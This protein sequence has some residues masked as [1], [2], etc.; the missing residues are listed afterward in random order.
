MIFFLRF[1]VKYRRLVIFLVDLS[2]YFIFLSKISIS[3]VVFMLKIFQL[4][5]SKEY[6]FENFSIKEK[7]LTQDV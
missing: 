1:R 4:P 6:L 3:M 7:L 2:L 5:S